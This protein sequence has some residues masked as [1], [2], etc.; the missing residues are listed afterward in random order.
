MERGGKDQREQEDKGY[1]KSVTGR[2]AECSNNYQRQTH[3]CKSL[4]VTFQRNIGAVVLCH[5]DIMRK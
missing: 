1:N 5:E 3:I 2:T 4:Q